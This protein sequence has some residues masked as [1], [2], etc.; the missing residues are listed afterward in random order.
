MGYVDSPALIVVEYQNA[1]VYGFYCGFY[2][3]D[4]FDFHCDGYDFDFH[5]DGYDFDFHCDGYDFD[6]DGNFDG[7]WY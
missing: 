2:R 7:D 6:F 4:D 3:Y 1:Y 5:C